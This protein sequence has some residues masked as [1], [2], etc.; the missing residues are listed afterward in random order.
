MGALM[1]FGQV[2]NFA[3]KVE[4]L[5]T[6]QTTTARTLGAFDERIVKLECRIIQI[7]ADRGQMIVRAKA[8]AGM[9]ASGVVSNLF[10]DIIT[11]ITR[12]DMRQAD[13]S[14]R[15]PPPITPA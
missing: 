11:R 3:C 2:W 8:A 1:S 12:L 13:G 9:A 7:G 14:T 6:L 15:R 4:E 10:V 5:F